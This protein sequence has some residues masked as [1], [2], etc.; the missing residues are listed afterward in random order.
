M[1]KKIPLQHQLDRAELERRYRGAADPV[2]RTHYQIIW[3]LAAGKTTSEVMGGSGYSRGWAQQVARRYNQHGPAGLG[4]R[5]RRTPGAAPLLD[6]AGQEALRGALAG[7]APDGGLWSGP[8]VAAWIA[9][10]LGRTVSERVG[11][12]DL[13]RVRYRPQVPRPPH[14]AAEAE[15]RAAFPKG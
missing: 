11:W 14:A 9:A 7:A 12:E 6:A 3:L 10:K 13:R 2:E 5:R 4:D 1:A 15:E 8:K